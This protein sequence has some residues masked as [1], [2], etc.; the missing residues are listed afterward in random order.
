MFSTWHFSTYFSYISTW[1]SHP[2]WEVG[3]C[4]KHILI[5]FFIPSLLC[6]PL[7]WF[8]FFFLF[9]CCRSNSGLCACS[10]S[11]VPLS[12]ICNPWGSVFLPS[13][14]LFQIFQLCGFWFLSLNALWI[15]FGGVGTFWRHFVTLLSQF[16]VFFFSVLR[17]VD[18]LQWVP[19]LNL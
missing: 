2:L 7:F 4:T 3:T 6:S 12:E 18:W 17:I 8:P 11:A 13:F 14:L 19:F 15:G 10:A 5:P 1:C 9:L 16:A